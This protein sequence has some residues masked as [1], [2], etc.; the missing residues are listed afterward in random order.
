MRKFVLAVLAVFGGSIG[1]MGFAP[2][3]SAQTPAI[4]AP[5]IEYYGDLPALEKAIL[6]PSGNYTAMLMTLQGQ[7]S[8]VVLDATGAPVKRLVVGEA[9]VRD[10]VWAGDAGILVLRTELGDLPKQYLRNEAEFLRGNVIPLDDNAQVISIFAAQRSIANAITGFYGVRQ[11]DGR[12]VGYFGGFRKGSRSGDRNRILDDAPALFAVDLLTGEADLADYAPDRPLTRRWLVSQ[13]GK[14]GARLDLDR[15]TARWSIRHRNGKTIAKGADALSRVN[16]LGFSRDGSGVFYQTYDAARERYVTR[17]ADADGTISAPPWGEIRVADHMIDPISGVVLGVR[18]T[19]SE[20][21]LG[22]NTQQARLQKVFDSFGSLASKSVEVANFTPDLSTLMVRTSGNYD[23]GT[24]FRV[25]AASGQR[26]IV[27]LERPAI[28]GQ[29]IGQ[30]SRFEYTATDGLEM[31]GVLTLPPGRDPTNLPVVLLPHGGPAAYDKVGFDWWAQGFASRGYA[32]F[33]PNFRGS[34]GRGAAF[35]NAGAGEWGRKMQTDL[36]DGLMALAEAGI[37]DPG[38]A[39]IAGAS[40]GGYASLAGVTMQQGLYRCAISVN[41][42]SDLERQLA[43]MTPS[44]TG[45][46]ARIMR[47]RLGKRTDLDTISPTQYARQTDAPVLLIHGLDDQVVPYGQSI[48]MRD[49]LRRADKPVTLISLEGEDHYLS[50]AET[51]KR[52]LKASVDFVM[53]HNPPD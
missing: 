17:L 41:G 36:S 26:A 35:E 3:V 33:Q 52:M 14:V 25:D 49:A 5:P 10:I 51:R 44:S 27:G 30:V 46:L 42:V 13:D 21:R 15:V 43:F 37:V 53:Q 23:S 20:Y 19:D 45:V 8:V 31:D 11:V 29:A 28:Q 2:P 40:Y 9:R 18:G 1:A 50:Q 6:S 7:R 48:L 38:R 24:W 47:S 39:C 22:D 16:F 12:W 32:V 4:A 34:T